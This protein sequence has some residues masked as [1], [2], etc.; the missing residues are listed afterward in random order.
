MSK[1]LKITKEYTP[2]IKPTRYIHESGFRC[3]EVGYCRVGKRNKVVSKKV[4]G[5]YTDHI[6]IENLTTKNKDVDVSLDLT[7]DGYIRFFGNKQ[8]KW[9]DDIA[10]S[11]MEIESINEKKCNEKIITRKKEKTTKIKGK[12][13][14]FNL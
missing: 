6:W 9:S 8:L 14:S 10:L 3:F 5:H 11:S 1:E 2:Y 13:F 7:R 12:Y 4:L